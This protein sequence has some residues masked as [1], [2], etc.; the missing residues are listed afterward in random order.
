MGNRNLKKL[1]NELNQ[2]CLKLHDD[3]CINYGGCCFVAYL[4]MKHFENLNIHPNLI[5]ESEY[6]EVNHKELFHFS[7][8][9]KF[10]HD[11]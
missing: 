11:K 1:V 2:V 4:L 7:K 5:I 3:Y 9:H 8:Q 6:E 10:L